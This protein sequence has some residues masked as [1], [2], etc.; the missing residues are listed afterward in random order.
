MNPESKRAPVL[1]V[2]GLSFGYRNSVPGR[3]AV[4]EVSFEVEEGEFVALLG[5]NGSGKSTLLKLISGVQSFEAGCGEG[6]VRFEGRDFFALPPVLRAA[7]VNYVGFGLAGEFP[8]TAFEAVLMARSIGGQSLF[9]AASQSDIDAVENAMRLCSC[10]ELGHRDLR[11]LSGGERQLVALA[12]A[13]AQGARVLL[14]DEALSQMDLHHQA[15]IGVFLRSLCREKGYTVLL[16]SH[17][18]NLATE[19]A[20]RCMLLRNGRLHKQGTCEEVLTSQTLS[21][22]YPEAPVWVG[23]HPVHGGPKIFFGSKI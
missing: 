19:W 10:H 12:R 13:I 4:H 21:E 20:S 6:Q 7:R 17:D 14:L 9:R 15:R 23:K 2:Y 3:A 22:L 8:L 18:W 16:V 1:G 5:P 11:E